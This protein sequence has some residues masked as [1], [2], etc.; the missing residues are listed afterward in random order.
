[1]V[2]IL[3]AILLVSGGTAVGMALVSQRHAPAPRRFAAGVLA[4]PRSAR[5]RPQL[6]AG[7]PP[8]PFHL[9]SSR[10]VSISIPAIGVHSVLQ[11]LGLNRNGTI[12][13]PPLGDT[14]RTNE[15][16]WFRYSATPGQIGVSVIEGHIDSAYQGPSVFFELG[17][18]VPGDQIDVALADRVEAI[19]TVRGVRQYE[20]TQFP[21]SAFYG[22][23]GAAA[24]HLVTCGGAFDPAT[25]RYLAS[26]V[27]VASLTSS[28]RLGR[29][30]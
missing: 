18:V 3:A 2:V 1:M 11:A 29:P 12:E 19:F 8:A 26:I 6:T 13:V 30:A 25:H 21:T 14:P 4:P 22:N 10:P 23:T 24:L 5:G 27:V 9:R 17:K 28:H 15:A 20:K 16:A 7:S